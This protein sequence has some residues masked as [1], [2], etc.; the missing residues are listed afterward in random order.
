MRLAFICL[1]EAYPP[2]SGAAYVTYNC[3]RF[4]PGTNLLVQL[5]QRGSV[6]SLDNLTIVSLQQGSHS[7]LAKLISFPLTILRIHRETA[8]FKPDC[9]VLE[10][11]SWVAYL[12][13][14]ALVLRR[15]LPNVKLIYH[16]HNV[17][18]LLRQERNS[19]LVVALTRRAEKYLLT[20]CNRS[21]AVSEDDRQRFFSLYGV[22][23]SLLPNGVDCSAYFLPQ[24]EIDS[25]QKRFG[26]TDE[27]ILFM[28]LYG[29]P[30]NTEA[31]RFLTEEVMPGLHL[32]RPNLR[33]VVTG[34]GP[35][36]SP[37][38]LVSTGVISRSD[39]NAVIC[40]CR[41]GMA[42]IFKGSG[43][44]LKILEYIAAGLPVVTTR[45]GAEGLN[46]EG[47]KHVLYAETA[48]E[49]QQ[50][51]LTLLDDSSISK[52][53]SLQAG[54]LVRSTF[55]WSQLLHQFAKELENL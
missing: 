12:A 29:Y 31:V 34:G 26:I 23:P 49:F 47:E 39:L 20:R 33:L 43:T 19:G 51:L 14:I 37:L 11:A 7:R 2:I 55:D 4:T 48:V 3:A 32:Q 15:T 17:E 54:T 36:T 44:R 30:P 28:G 50:A 45:K 16:A 53:L 52:R 9:V 46:L 1:Y 25:V 40:A 10:G 35:P 38:W 41:I 27:S 8:R 5:A 24:A 21:F 6:T 22:L 18:Y 13:L 42:P